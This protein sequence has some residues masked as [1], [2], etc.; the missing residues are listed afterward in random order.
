MG[1][2]LA[3]TLRLI[4]PNDHPA[5]AAASPA[6]P[7]VRDEIGIVSPWQTGELSQVVWADILTDDDLLPMTRGEAMS[8][9][10]L[11]KAR[12][13]VAPKVAD[14]PLRAL[15]GET[16][17]NP[18]PSWISRS[19]DPVSPWHRMLWT[20]DDLIFH[21]WSLWHATRGQANVLLAASRI[22]KD[23]WAFADD[24][25]LKVDGQPVR[26]PLSVILIPGPHEGILNFGRH[27]IRHARYLV[28]AATNAAR[29][30]S[31]TMEL[32]QTEGETLT[33]A[34]QTDLIAKWSAARQGVNAGV[35]YTNRVIETKEHNS[36]EA[37]LLIDG[38][39]AAAVDMARNVGVAAAMVDATTP[40]STLA[41]ET[42]Q[43][44]GLEHRAY[45]L[46]PYCSAIAARLSLDD[47]CPRGQRVAFDAS[48]D[49]A[50]AV[51]PLG[52]PLED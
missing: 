19:D 50:T 8:V 41:Y 32:H 33:D 46:D 37:A 25:T 43:G 3:S 20:V 14:T 48:E 35:A 1:N 4:R 23:R 28:E 5:W 7:A 16:E 10:S 47:V 18:Q 39:N 17:V 26:N 2:R 44:R 13:V 42:Q 36:I 27:S 6:V 40:K 34:E 24:W 29:N 31:P 21:G 38:R 30:P 45:G 22:A 12:H 15:R 51:P 11:A 9:P 49:V 52:P